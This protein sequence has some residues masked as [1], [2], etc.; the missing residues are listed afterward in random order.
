[1][2]NEIRK[3][4]KSRAKKQGDHEGVDMP[5]ALDSHY[6]DS[7]MHNEDFLSDPDD[8]DMEMHMDNEMGNEDQ[9]E[10]REEAKKRKQKRMSRI[11]KPVEMGHGDDNAP[12]KH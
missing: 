4:M 2:V 6:D 1:M 3:R 7:D 12:G 10:A 5:E 11:M 8:M 9:D